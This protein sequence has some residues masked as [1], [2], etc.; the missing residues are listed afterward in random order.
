MRVGR[1]GSL[2]RLEV[3]AQKQLKERDLCQRERRPL[4]L[5]RRRNLEQ[6]DKNKGEEPKERGSKEGPLV[7][8]IRPTDPPCKLGLPCRLFQPSR[9]TCKTEIEGPFYRCEN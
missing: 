5:C 1:G 3:K 4:G 9:Q 2:E 7:Q 8:L 6:R